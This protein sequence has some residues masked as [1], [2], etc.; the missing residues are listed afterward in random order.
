MRKIIL[1]LLFASILFGCDET[2]SKSITELTFEDVE[3]GIL[4]DVRTPQEYNKGHIEQSINIDWLGNEFLET[5]KDLNKNK[6]VYVYCKKGGRSAKA[7]KF[8]DSLGF[9]RVIDLKG[10][11]DAYVSKKKGLK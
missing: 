7:A 5:A 2:D 3:T 8:L 1:V 6:P 9:E 10:G 4:L 11:Y